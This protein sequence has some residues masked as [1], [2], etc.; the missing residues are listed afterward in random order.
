MSRPASDRN[1]AGRESFHGGRDSSQGGDAS[2]DAD[3]ERSD[4]VEMEVDESTEGGDSPMVDPDD[5]PSRADVDD[6]RSA[7]PHPTY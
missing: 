2:R 4:D 5:P 6:S 1:M 3:A 7:L